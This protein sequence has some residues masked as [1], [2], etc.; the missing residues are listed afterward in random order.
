MKV[1]TLI[2]ID[3]DRVKEF[4]DTIYKNLAYE[5]FNDMTIYKLKDVSE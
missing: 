5:P 2:D 1:I 4:K 3:E